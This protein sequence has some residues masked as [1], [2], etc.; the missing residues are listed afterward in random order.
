ML[1]LIPV[2]SGILA[3]INGGASTSYGHPAPSPHGYFAK[4]SN[5]SK[6]CVP[7]LGSLK[8]NKRQMFRIKHRCERF[9]VRQENGNGSLY[10]P[11]DGPTTSKYYYDKK[12]NMCLLV[13][14][15]IECTPHKLYRKLK[16]CKELCEARDASPGTSS[17]TPTE[18]LPGC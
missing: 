3:T 16:R 8:C 6:V 14:Q 11:E 13:P 15:S 5:G 7:A 9:C 10:K 12:Y 2:V 17:P 18:G 4:W 1:R